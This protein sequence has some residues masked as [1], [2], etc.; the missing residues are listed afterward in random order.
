M[1]SC[2]NP[3]TD[4]WIRKKFWLNLLSGIQDNMHNCLRRVL[5]GFDLLISSNTLVCLTCTMHTAW[6][7]LRRVTPVSDY[8]LKYYSNQSFAYISA[9]YINAFLSMYTVQYI[10]ISNKQI[11]MKK[12]ILRLYKDCQANFK[13]LILRIYRTH[14]SPLPEQIIF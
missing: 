13:W 7:L 2:F 6:I 11:Q 3:L 1:Y 8:G 12:Y 4:C 14:L 5:L 10:Y 9:K